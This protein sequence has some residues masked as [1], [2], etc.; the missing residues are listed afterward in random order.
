MPAVL[1]EGTQRGWACWALGVTLLISRTFAPL[2]EVFR[3]SSDKLALCHLELTRKLQDLIK[4]VL[5]YSEE[6]LKMHKKVCAR[7]ALPGGV[8]RGHQRLKTAQAFRGLPTSSPLACASENSETSNPEPH[9][10]GN[11]QTFQTLKILDQRSAHWGQIQPMTYFYTAHELRM[12]ITFLSGG[13]WGKSKEE[14]DFV[15]REND[16]TLR[17]QVSGFIGT[18]PCPFVYR[19][20]D[21]FRVECP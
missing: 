10:P 9:R 12:V 1:S 16:M 21:F 7:Q 13:W 2:W 15:K 6:Q 3:V 19:V 8:G 18:K 17:F 5:R 20:C 14:E 11:Y 4:D